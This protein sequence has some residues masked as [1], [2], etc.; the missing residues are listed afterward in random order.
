MD[1][2]RP[3]EFRRPGARIAR[4]E[5]ERRGAPAFSDRGSLMLLQTRPLGASKLIAPKRKD[6]DRPRMKGRVLV[7][8]ARRS[9]WTRLD[10]VSSDVQAR[11]SP[12]RSGSAVALPLSRTGVR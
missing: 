2:A 4:A 8:A 7:D 10:R 6:Q 3:C 11:A 1:E 9:E 12:G 5:R